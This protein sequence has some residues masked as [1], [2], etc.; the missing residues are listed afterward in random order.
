MWTDYHLR[1]ESEEAF[2]AATPEDWKDEEGAVVGEDGVAVD[3]IGPV[4]EWFLVNVRI[5]GEL[6]SELADY[7]IETPA[8]PVRV[9]A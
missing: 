2:L 9:W 3:V 5:A 7:V 1:A 8:N 4:G 6:P